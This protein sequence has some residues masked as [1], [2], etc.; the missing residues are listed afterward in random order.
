MANELTIENATY[1]QLIKSNT[2][3]ALATELHLTETQRV[4]AN[5]S[6]LVLLGDEKLNGTTQISK[7]RYCY[8]VATLNYKN[9]N[10]IAPIKYGDSVQAQLQYQAY[11][12]D[13]KDCGGVVETN[14]VV[15]FKDIDYKPHKNQ[16]GFTELELPE[17]IELKDPFQKLEIIG[18]Y[19]YAKCVDGRVATC[20]MSKSECEE[21]AM[22]YSK[23]QRA[24][25]AGKA[26]SSVWNDQFETMSLKTCIKAVARQVLKWFPFDR[27]DNAIQLDQAVFTNK[28]IEYVDNE[29]DP[30]PIETGKVK[31][32]LPNNE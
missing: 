26:S 24:F 32:E 1:E 5:N 11:I 20:V 22:K 9:T 31:V 21:Y 29:N 2:A 25:K 14:A 8:R 18:F 30:K 19:A 6:L 3:T 17:S 27:L 15:L 10:A 12:E 23:S 4:K 16:L 7:L 28:G 13:M